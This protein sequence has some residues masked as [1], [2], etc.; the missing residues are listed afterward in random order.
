MRKHILQKGT[1]KESLC[2]VPLF[3]YSLFLL[4]LH[5]LNYFFFVRSLLFGNTRKNSVWNGQKLL[6][7]NSKSI[8]TR[9]PDKK[10]KYDYFGRYKF[11]ARQKKAV[12][13]K[14]RISFIRFF[15]LVGSAIKFKLQ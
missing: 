12:D 2:Y 7:L 8:H 9:L 14:L 3:S 6:H 11:D 5:D 1:K 4:T 15:F 10:K 13:I